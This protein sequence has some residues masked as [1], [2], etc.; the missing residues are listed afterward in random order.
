MR[1]RVLAGIAMGAAILC[2]VQAKAADAKEWVTDFKKAAETAKKSGKYML[3]DFT[4]TDWCVWCV[5]LKRE[6]FSHKEFKEFAKENLVCVLLDFPRW[7]KQPDRI[8]QQNQALMRKYRIRG[9]PTIIILS[10]KGEGVART[11]YRW[12]GAAAYVTH[13]KEIID[14]HKAKVEKEEGK[15]E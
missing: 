6:V 8:K 4:G 10:P 14:A 12:G 15:K 11:G 2:C 9:I 3:L 1:V 5:R 7:K 13:L